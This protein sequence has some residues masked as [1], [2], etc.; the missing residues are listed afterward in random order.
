MDGQGWDENWVG[1]MENTKQ[2]A[3]VSPR[4][5]S[6]KPALPLP[7]A[8]LTALDE[9]W[10]DVRACNA[11]LLRALHLQNPHCRWCGRALTSPAQAATWRALGRLRCSDC[12]RWCTPLTNT[13]L[14]KSSLDPR[15]YV[16][17][18]LLALAGLGDRAI[19]Q[20]LKVSAETIRRWLTPWRDAA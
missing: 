4:Q 8:V 11:W 14:S 20:R 6:G 17:L 1:K 18:C 15:R 9:T 10:L 7:E 13:P 12:G 16:L 5:S 2:A 19:A 3:V